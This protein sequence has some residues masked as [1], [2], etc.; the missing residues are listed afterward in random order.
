M[1]KILIA[2][3]EEL[4]RK[5]LIYSINWGEL[6]CNV[7]AEASNGEE[8]INKIKEFQPDIVIAD[9]NMPI[10]NGIDMIKSTVEY[11]NYSAIIISGYNEFDYAKQAIRY[12]VSEYL[13]KPLDHKELID[14]IRRAI[15]QIEMK[16]VYQLQLQQKKNVIDTKVIDSDL[17]LSI[18][19]SLA[20]SKMIEYIKK[21][22]NKKIIMFDLVE[23]LQCSATLLNSKFKKETGTTFN[24]F[25]NRYRILMAVQMIKDHS[26]PLY[27]IAEETGFK[28]YKYFNIVFHKYIG[29]SPKDFE[30]VAL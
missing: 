21:N 14:A 11:F 27:R 19:K 20:V 24:D 30:N 10:I 22:Y 18:N 6:N 4:I 3:D 26:L 8:G 12:G 5:G 29:C 1:Y 17:L 13:L 23:E 28:N 16:K 15:E 7:I 25:L 2:E 9:I